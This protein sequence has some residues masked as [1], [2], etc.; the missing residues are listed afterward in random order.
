MENNGYCVD[1][2][3]NLDLDLEVLRLVKNQH[4]ATDKPK[5]FAIKLHEYDKGLQFVLRQFGLD[6]K[7]GEIFYSPPG[8]ELP[9][10][11]DDKHQGRNHSKL[12]WVF[13]APGSVMQ[14][15]ST[16]SGYQPE[17]KTTEIGTTYFLFDKQQCNILGE[18]A[19]GQPSLVNVG[20]PHSV[21]NNTDQGR[22]C[23][24]YMLREKDTT[25]NLQW[26]VAVHKFASL[27]QR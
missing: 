19:I 6:I 3:L 8:Y 14:W 2:D 7:H 5:Q 16:K 12:N 27:A 22:W 20:I 15:W 11:I 10:H 25:Q 9:I 21:V 26:D 1:I 23:V 4:T 17:K 13:G 24:S 18:A